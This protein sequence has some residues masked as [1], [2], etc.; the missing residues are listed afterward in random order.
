MPYDR[1]FLGRFEHLL[2]APKSRAE[3]FEHLSHPVVPVQF[4]VSRQNWMVT[5]NFGSV[6]SG[7]V[8]IETSVFFSERN[9]TTSLALLLVIHVNYVES[10]IISCSNVRKLRAT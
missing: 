4:W 2:S 8:P 9:G 1:S 5:P 10:D 6:W 7:R 3:K